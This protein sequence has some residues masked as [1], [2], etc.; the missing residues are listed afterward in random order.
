L[1][2]RLTRRNLEDGSGMF[3]QIR[4]RI[5]VA[6]ILKLGLLFG[7]QMNFKGFRHDTPP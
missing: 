1:S 6:H 5:M 7:G 4:P 2:P 3:P